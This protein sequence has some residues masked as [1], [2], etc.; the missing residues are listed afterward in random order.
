M[1]CRNLR[2]AKSPVCYGLFWYCPSTGTVWNSLKSYEIISAQ[3]W[4]N[5]LNRVRQVLQNSPYT[6]LHTLWQ[7]APVHIALYAIQSSQCSMRKLAELL[8]P[9]ARYPGHLPA[10]IQYAQTMVLAKIQQGQRHSYYERLAPQVNCTLRTWIH[11]KFDKL[12]N[13]HIG[14]L[15]DRY[16]MFWPQLQSK[17]CNNNIQL[18]A[19][20]ESLRQTHT[21]QACSRLMEGPMRRHFEFGLI[22]SGRIV[23]C[24]CQRPKQSALDEIGYFMVFYDSWWVM[25][26]FVLR[27]P[28]LLSSSVLLALCWPFNSSSQESDPAVKE[29]CR[30]SICVTQSLHMTYAAET[31]GTDLETV[32]RCT[33]DNLVCWHPFCRLSCGTE[34]PLAMPWCWKVDHQSITAEFDD[35]TPVRIDKPEFRISMSKYDKSESRIKSWRQLAAKSIVSGIQHGFRGLLRISQTACVGC[36]AHFW[37][38]T[39]PNFNHCYDCKFAPVFQSF[40]IEKLN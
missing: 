32:Q 25:M 3:A 15:K 1:S 38:I 35:V 9:S 36:S 40:P 10:E 21:M 29:V 26:I 11:W 37:C 33:C 16:A 5:E 6:H 27:C 7:P 17:L 28:S 14:R 18:I 23:H 30:N 12:Y 24:L 20:I 13:S 2:W 34:E 8:S 22:A 19:F 4:S 39:N 31:A